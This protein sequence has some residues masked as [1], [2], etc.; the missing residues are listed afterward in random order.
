MFYSIFI[1][2][3]NVIITVTELLLEKCKC[4]CKI[5]FLEK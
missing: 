2:N 1:R 5:F 3:G 4:N